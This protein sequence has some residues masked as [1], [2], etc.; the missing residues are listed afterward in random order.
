MIG[1]IHPSR[2]QKLLSSP[3]HRNFKSSHSNSKSR[4][5]M[6][7][8]SHPYYIGSFSRYLSIYLS[9]IFKYDIAVVLFIDGMNYTRHQIIRGDHMSF[10]ARASAS[11]GQDL[12]GPVVC[13]KLNFLFN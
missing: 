12:L 3:S 10:N 5:P 2:F 7:Y 8:I 1:R 11:H 4:I 13:A 6:I 9:I